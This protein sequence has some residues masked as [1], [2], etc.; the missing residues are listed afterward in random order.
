MGNESH[1][2]Y[3]LLFLD[4]TYRGHAWGALGEQVN[5]ACIS[6]KL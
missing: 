5:R 3:C 2:S 4:N 1:G 6:D